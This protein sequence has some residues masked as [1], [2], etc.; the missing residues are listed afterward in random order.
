MGNVRKVTGRQKCRRNN[1][2]VVNVIDLND[3]FARISTDLHYKIPEPKFTASQNLQLFTEYQVFRMDDTVKPSAFGLDGLPDWFIRLAAPVFAQPLI[4]L[5][6]L[7]NP[8]F[9]P[10]GSLVV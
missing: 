5:F 1:C 10:S 7:D 9:L 4:H 3:H 2:S 6:N 8:L